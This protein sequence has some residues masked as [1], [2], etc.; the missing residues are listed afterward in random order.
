MKLGTSLRFIFAESEDSLRKYHEVVVDR[1]EFS[2]IPLGV[3]DVRLQARQLLEIAK[4]AAECDFGFLMV[5]DSHASSYANA[6]APTPTLARMLAVTGDMPVGLLYLAPFH[7]PVLAAEQVG[8]LAAFAPEPLTLIVG[9]GDVS[10]QFDAF[11][12]A[13]GSRGR[14]SEEFITVVRR[15]LAG[16]RFS[17]DGEFFQF[18]NL[19]INPIPST[20]AEIW[21]AAMAGKAVERAGRLGDAWETAPGTAPEVLERQLELYSRI[22]SENGRVPKAV[23]RRD[24]YVAET[25][26]K[27]WEAVEP[28]VAAGYRGFGRERDTSLVGSAETVV[29]RLEFYRK[30]GF[31]TVL[32]RHIVGDHQLILDS[33]RRIG[34]SVIPAIVDL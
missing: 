19:R 24:I 32:V 28:V 22:C 4:T 31:E 23:L 33:L 29:K 26:E 30:I 7:H 17:H 15:L 3:T 8:T 18:D 20:P 27:A 2:D 13:K 6:F 1:G 21:V 12:I 16:E 5:G 14:R 34:D 25:D 9:N 11:K 10:E